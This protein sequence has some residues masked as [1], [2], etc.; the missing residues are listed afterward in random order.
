MSNLLLSFSLKKSHYE[1]IALVALYK[2]ATVSESLSLQ[3]SG[4]SESLFRSHKQAIVFT[5][6]LNV[7]HCYSPF[8]VPLLFAP[9]LFTLF[10][11]AMGANIRSLEKRKSLFCSFAHKK[12]SISSK[13][14]RANSQP[15]LLSLARSVSFLAPS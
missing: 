5:M 10:K 3:K 15:C 9:L 7:F 14:R 13:K 12:L 2:R 1:Q 4:E 8:N 6:F 11:R